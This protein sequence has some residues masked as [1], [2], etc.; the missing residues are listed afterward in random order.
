MPYRGG[1]GVL[2]LVAAVGCATAGTHRHEAPGASTT[3]ISIVGTNDLHGGVLPR[4]DR[5]GLALLGGYVANLRAARSA[6]GGAVLLLDAGDMFQGTLESNL[7][8]GAVVVRAYNALGYAAAAVGNHEFDFGP[9]G[10]ESTAHDPAEDPRGALKARAAEAAF[11]WLAAN[12]ID[13][14]TGRTVNWPN[15]RPAAMV[16]AASMP[17]GII[18]VMTMEAF[19]ATL[20]ANTR[21]LRLAP[22]LETVTAQAR[23]LR[24]R[25][26]AVVV[27]VAHEGG[28]CADF[29]DAHDLSSC[30]ATAP[31]VE[32]ARTLPAG[33]VDVIVAGHSHA[34]VAHQIGDVAVIEAYANGR[35]FGRVDVRVDRAARRVI[36]RRIF[37]PRDLCA[38]VDPGTARCDTDAAGAARVTAEYEGRPVT[39]DAA[40]ATI[41]RPAVEAASALKAT[42]LGVM[43]DTPVRRAGPGESALGNL[44]ADAYLAALPGADAA[45]NNTDGGLRADLPA[46]PATYGSLFE[47]MPFDNRV[48]GLSLTGADFRRLIAAWMGSLTPPLPGIAGLRARVACRGTALDV[49]LVRPNGAVVGDDERL[50]VATIDFLVT[51]GDG[52]LTPIAPAGGLTIVRDAGDARA[53]AVAELKRYAPAL[54]ASQLSDPDNPRWIL[55]GPRPVTCSR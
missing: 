1:I 27:V 43:L 34:G 26:A 23:T 55:P 25:G 54:R 41:L 45:I 44:V 15:V 16:R 40:V 28:R 53:A 49:T 5:G 3:T 21:G 51:G 35:A 31:I 42:P 6:D 24:A 46:G 32:L 30:D 18:G 7:N 2:A 47:V 50:L 19:S 37:A 8:E 36:E 13:T 4:G 10:P 33:L 17:V 20:A 39:A 14:N 12:L 48:V 22:L 11:P 9:V 29:S 52:V 38:R